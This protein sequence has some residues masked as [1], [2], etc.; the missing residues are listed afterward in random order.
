MHLRIIETQ[1]SVIFV[2]YL[3]RMKAPKGMQLVLQ[4]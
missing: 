2:V 4:E 3:C 1:F